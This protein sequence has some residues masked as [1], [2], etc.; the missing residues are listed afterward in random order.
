MGECTTC[1]GNGFIVIGAISEPCPECW[2]TGRDDSDDD[3]VEEGEDSDE[4]EEGI[5]GA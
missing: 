5:S 1:F 3:D 2:G 4:D